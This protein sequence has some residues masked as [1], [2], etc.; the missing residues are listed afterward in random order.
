M[1]EPADE[2]RTETAGADAAA[3]VDAIPA[4]G[5]DA[6]AQKP[7]SRPPAEIRADL[8]KERVELGASFDALRVDLEE[9]ADGAR[10]RAAAVGRKAKI[11]APAVGAAVAAALFLR[12]RARRKR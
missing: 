5:E 6:A 3:R 2:A 12:S 8:F 10:N 7:P 1:S 4:A 9:A 11:I